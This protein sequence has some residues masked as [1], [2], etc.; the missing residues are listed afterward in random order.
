VGIL[1][2]EGRVEVGD[3]SAEGD[4]KAPSA[5]HLAEVVAVDADGEDRLVEEDASALR[6][7]EATQ[8]RRRHGFQEADGRVTFLAR[9]HRERGRGHIG[10]LVRRVHVVLEQHKRLT[11]NSCVHYSIL[12]PCRTLDTISLLLIPKFSNRNAPSSP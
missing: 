6:H 8:L 3:A 9:V 7:R 10:D 11:H 2:G 12:K 5:V 1:V 4:G